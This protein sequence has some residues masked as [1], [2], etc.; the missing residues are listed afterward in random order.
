MKRGSGVG[1]GIH[2]SGTD[3]TV[4]RNRRCGVTASRLLSKLVFNISSPKAQG[5]QPHDG[6]P[7]F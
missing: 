3:L 2:P 4:L 1:S 6:T 7:L 5:L